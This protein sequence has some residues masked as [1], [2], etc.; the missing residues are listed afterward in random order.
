MTI[1]VSFASVDQRTVIDNLC[2]W[3]LC[4]GCTGGIPGI[5]DRV[6]ADY[7]RHHLVLLG[8]NGSPDGTV[9]PVHLHR[10]RASVRRQL[11]LISDWL[12][13]K[14]ACPGDEPREDD[15]ATLQI[16]EADKKCLI[17]IEQLMEVVHC[18][19]GY[20]LPTPVR[21]VSVTSGRTLL[22]GGL[23][24]RMIV[25]R[26]G[27]PVEWAGCARCLPDKEEVPAAIPRQSLGRWLRLR[28][29]S[30]EDWTGQVLKRAR[31]NSRGPG[32]AI[33]AIPFDVY[34]PHSSAEQ[35]RRW[36]A[37]NLWRRTK[38]V[39]DDLWLCR[40]Q[41]RPRRF[42][43]ASFSRP[44]SGLSFSHVLDVQP[45][46]SR[47][48]MY[49]LDQRAG[50]PVRVRFRRNTAGNSRV[51]SLGSWPTDEILRLLI[52]LGHRRETPTIDGR[53]V[54]LP[55]H[56]EVAD[57]WWHDVRKAIETLGM[58]VIGDQTETTGRPNG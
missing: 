26:W 16:Q 9:R 42:W 37:S 18:G 23:S 3:A 51:V 22:L 45:E 56:F 1:A 25:K 5:R 29:M 24:T 53:C 8:S 52:A 41:Q 4:Q 55:L 17:V 40:S 36:V 14:N 6:V 39:T 46:D 21:A 47:R 20:Y 33:D 10:L 13:D 11:G 30:L 50:Q 19:G 32:A 49:G 27:C 12:I 15:E 43:L 34:E 58:K 44:L 48:L 38:P 2:D 7:L 35:H 28:D 31:D 57:A 54:H